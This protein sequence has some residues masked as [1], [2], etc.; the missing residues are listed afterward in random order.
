MPDR[1]HRGRHAQRLTA[2]RCSQLALKRHPSAY[3]RCLQTAGAARLV[4]TRHVAPQSQDGRWAFLVGSTVI[5]FGFGRA[6]DRPVVAD[7]D[8]DGREE[9]GIFRAGE[10][11][12]RND[13]SA[14]P[15]WRVFRYGTR[16]DTPLAGR[17]PGSS[18]VSVAVVRGNVYLIG[19]PLAGQFGCRRCRCPGQRLARAKWVGRGCGAMDLLVRPGRR[20]P[21]GW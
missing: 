19:R 17:W 20:H 10:W 11:H 8:N 14:G 2:D 6:G 7:F 15:A 4:P 5:R 1:S 3:P 21:S 13:A 16:G 9:P 18:G 12:I